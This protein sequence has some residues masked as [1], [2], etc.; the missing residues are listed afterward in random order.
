M[1]LIGYV[2]GP[3]MGGA[4]ANKNGKP[5]A[6]RTMAK[7]GSV[8]CGVYLVLSV[9]IFCLEYCKEQNTKRSSGNKKKDDNLSWY[10][11]EIVDQRSSHH[12]SQES[13]S[14]HKSDAYLRHATL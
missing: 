7:I 12:S 14:N 9:I 4:L 1:I 6:C 3:P 8:Y 2:M 5:E 13:E 11:S 10:L